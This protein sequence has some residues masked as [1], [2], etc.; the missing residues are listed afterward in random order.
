[1]QHTGRHNSG[2]VTTAD[3]MR[4][5]FTILIALHGLIH[6]IGPAKA[7]GWGNVTQLRQPISP[8][9]GMLWLLAAVLLIGSAAAVAISARWWWYL[10]L[11]GALLSQYLIVQAW[12]D[13][14]VGTLA[15]IVI[16]VPLV[17]L[18]LDARPGSFRSRFAQR[19]R[20]AAGPTGT[21]C[22]DRDR[23]RHRRPPAADADL[24][25]P[26]RCSRPA[27]RAQHADHVR[28]PDAQQRHLAMDAVDE[29]SSM[30]SSIRRHACST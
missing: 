13:A 27:T 2:D 22:A 14:K 5:A 28:R 8:A 21:A 30:S 16:A 18:A 12:G 6:L 11:P 3:T 25:A 4:I 24:P 15:N 29:S 26:R 20:R 7:F 10:A 17:L 9:S 23:R 19:P 1:M